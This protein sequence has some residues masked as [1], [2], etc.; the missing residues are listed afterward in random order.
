MRPMPRYRIKNTTDGKNL[1]H[2]FDDSSAQIIMPNGYVM[3]VDEVIEIEG[4]K[5]FVNANYIVDAELA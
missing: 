4:G 5:R 3:A 2:D 1:G